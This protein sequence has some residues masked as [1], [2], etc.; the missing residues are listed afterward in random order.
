M[1][2]FNF[3][4]HGLVIYKKYKDTLLSFCEIKKF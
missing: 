1:C 4:V 3:V 2:Y